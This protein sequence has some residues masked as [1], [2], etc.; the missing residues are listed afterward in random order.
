MFRKITM[1]A[2]CAALLSAAACSDPEVPVAVDANE[3][4][5]EAA[6]AMGTANLDAITYSGTA[7][8]AR[9]SFMQTPNANPPW[10]VHDLANYRRTIDL[11][12]PASLATGEGFHG[13]LFMT[14]P[15]AQPYTQN[16]AAGQTAW[17][18]QLEIWLTPWG[19]LKGAAAN[20]AEAVSQMMD[21]TQYTIVTWKSPAEQTAPS[22][23]QYTVTGYLTEDNLVDHVETW[24][25]DPIMGD[26]H[27]VARYSDYQ[28]FGGVQVPTRMVQ[29][30]GG[31]SVFE[32]TVA[33]ATANPANVAELLTPPPPPAGRGGGAGRAGGPGGGRAGA[34]GG[35]RGAPAAPTELA[36]QVGDGVYLIGGGYVAL[37]AEFA[38]HVAVFE[39][40][41][42]EARGQQIVDEVKR[43]LPNKPIR[44]IINSHPHS[45]HSAGL[46]PFL[47][48]GA[49]LITQSNNVEFMRMAFSS[50]R[51]LLGQETMTPTVE[52]VD[53]LR[54][55]EDDT[56]RLELHS[57]PNLHTD[58]M[59]VA[60]LPKQ[61]IL[62]Q[63]DFTLPQPG[64]AANPFVVALAERIQAL[65]LD[66]DRYLAVH[67]AAQ[68]QTKADLM[69]VL[70]K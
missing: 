33:D 7:K 27:V 70:E 48:E 30:R 47:R 5:S 21:G 65:N 68:P 57:V 58:G 16:I 11:T 1:A 60:F 9:N 17:G 2:A 18:Q 59:L 25:E 55:L 44:Y 22:G 26:M 32:V 38:D 24:V 52:G 34:P 41:Q 6:A 49:T 8:M 39:G 4:L 67:A 3:A 37:V 23:L 63:A 56:N 50:P 54:V 36:E 28:D 13:G 69:A 62:F 42:S 15:T 40:G 45:D 51:T 10:P 20:N 46:A 64:Q 14:E 61:K 29:E 19:F 31:G 12:Q 53:E 35:G 66:F 43:I